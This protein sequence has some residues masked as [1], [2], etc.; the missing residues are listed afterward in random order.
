MDSLGK[1]KIVNFCRGQKRDA[2]LISKKTVGDYIAKA[3]GG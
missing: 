3:N 2:L 1:K